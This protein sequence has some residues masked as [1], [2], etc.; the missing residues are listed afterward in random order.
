MVNAGFATRAVDL[1][2][3][4]LLCRATFVGPAHLSVTAWTAADFNQWRRAFANDMGLLEGGLTVLAVF[5]LLAALVNREPLYIVFAAWLIVKH[6]ARRQLGRL[7]HALAGPPGTGRLARR[8]AQA[9]L[10]QQLPADRLT[11]SLRLFQAD[12]R[13]VGSARW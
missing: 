13:S 2:G 8:N 7:G 3:V 10:R 9:H 11:S 5:M 4:P 12:L 1:S 6:A